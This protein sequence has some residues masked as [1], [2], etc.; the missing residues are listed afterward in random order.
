MGKIKIA[1][2][3]KGANLAGMSFARACKAQATI[4]A[5]EGKKA[6]DEFMAK[7]E[8][9]GIEAAKAKAR[10]DLKRRKDA[11]RNAGMPVTVG[12]R[13]DLVT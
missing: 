2:T 12:G 7:W 13:D 1:G 4:E 8:A 11:Q 6:A 9:A 3:E 10:A 5:H